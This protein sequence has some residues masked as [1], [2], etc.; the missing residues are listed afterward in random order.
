MV[1]VYLLGIAL[2]IYLIKKIWD[3]YWLV[4]LTNY[5]TKDDKDKNE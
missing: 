4:K 1:I 3:F 5:I 2:A